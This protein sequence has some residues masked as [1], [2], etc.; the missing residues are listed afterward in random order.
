V[1][2]KTTYMPDILAARSG[3][4]AISVHRALKHIHAT[5]LEC[6]PEGDRPTDVQAALDDLEMMIHAAA[7]GR[8]LEQESL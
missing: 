1:T 4:S 5:L 8:D 2:I 3:Y 6:E 7:N